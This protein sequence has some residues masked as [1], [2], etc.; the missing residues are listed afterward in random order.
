MI[1]AGFKT[2][3]FWTYQKRRPAARC[4]QRH[5]VTRAIWIGKLVVF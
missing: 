2:N 4:G 1:Q 3:T 5:N